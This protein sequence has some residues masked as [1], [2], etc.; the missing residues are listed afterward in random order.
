MHYVISS[1]CPGVIYEEMDADFHMIKS[2]VPYRYQ[3]HLR[4]ETFPDNEIFCMVTNTANGTLELRVNP[5]VHRMMEVIYENIKQRVINTQHRWNKIV[6]FGGSFVDDW[7]NQE[8]VPTV[9][10]IW[11]LEGDFDVSVNEFIAQTLTQKERVD[12][13]LVGLVF[14]R[15]DFIDWW[16]APRE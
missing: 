7:K 1:E 5:K 4:P 15:E 3:Y 8:N 2:V 6:D 11:C 10:C 9:S 16:F 14:R 13:G 12:L